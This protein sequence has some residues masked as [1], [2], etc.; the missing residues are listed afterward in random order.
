MGF[1]LQEAERLGAPRG[2]PAGGW[3]LSVTLRPEL[4]AHARDAK[5]TGETHAH[6]CLRSRRDSLVGHVE[7]R[8]SGEK[9][10]EQTILCAALMKDPADVWQKLA[11]DSYH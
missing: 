2:S 9:E 6:S 8:E 10:R 1:S 4:R 11:K 3:L 5:Y 7:P